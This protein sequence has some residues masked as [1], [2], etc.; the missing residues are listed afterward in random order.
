[1]VKRIIFIVLL[2][3][4]GFS[5][6]LFSHPLHLT[7]TNIDIYNDSIKVAIRI[8]ISDFELAMDEYNNITRQK[9]IYNTEDEEL[10][11][12]KRYIDVHFKI[13]TEDENII[14]ILDEK[15]SDDAVLWI[16]LNGQFNVN[17]KTLLIENNLLRNLNSDQRNMVI[18][19]CNHKENGYEFTSTDTKKTITLVP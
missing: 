11:L 7:L 14:L 2:I 18:V 13:S 3:L 9:Y 17:E 5:S 1:M 12:I 6:K 19:N 15:Q 16:Y 10:E 8:L 4:P